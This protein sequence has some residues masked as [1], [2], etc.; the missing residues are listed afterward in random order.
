MHVRRRSRLARVAFTSLSLGVSA[1]ASADAQVKPPNAAQGVV[2]SS[3]AFANATFESDSLAGWTTPAGA[4]P[5]TARK[6][7]SERVQMS[8]H[9]NAPTTL[10]IGGNY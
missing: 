3:L 10:P 4:L 8:P 6:C 2:G 5:A 1:A 9:P 7:G